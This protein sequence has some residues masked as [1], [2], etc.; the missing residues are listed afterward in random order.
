MLSL[1]EEVIFTFRKD[2]LDFRLVSSKIIITKINWI[3]LS[4]T[5]INN[6]WQKVYYKIILNVIKE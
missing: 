5:K 1:W 4:K 3:A 6:E 2:N